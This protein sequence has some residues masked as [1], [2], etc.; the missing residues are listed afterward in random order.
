MIAATPDNG[1]T[2]NSYVMIDKVNTIKRSQGGVRIGLINADEQ[3]EIDLA[4]MLF[5][6]LAG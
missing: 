1:L 2:Q 4:L 6:G 3:T 5:L